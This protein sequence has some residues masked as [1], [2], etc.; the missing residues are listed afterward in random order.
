MLKP[1]PGDTRG[2]LLQV[3]ETA[4]L[5]AS[6]TGG[7]DIAL[8]KEANLCL[9]PPGIAQHTSRF[10]LSILAG[11][12][13]VTIFRGNHLP[14]AARMNLDY[15]QFT[16]N[17]EPDEAHLAPII[18]SNLLNDTARLWQM[19]A[20]L[21]DVQSQFLWSSKTQHSVFGKLEQELAVI[22]NT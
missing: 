11:C 6:W 17:M 9:C 4:D 1:T 3:W 7:G 16:L 19:K 22:A 15:T 14:F 21:A 12:V 13:P 18:V 5:P 8:S 2:E 10:F 20:A